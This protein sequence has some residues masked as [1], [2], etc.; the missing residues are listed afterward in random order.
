MSA[1][2]KPHKVR[3]RQLE[4][5]RE[6]DPEG[7]I[8]VH[9]RTVDTLGKMLRSGTISQEMHEA[10]KD[11][12]AAFIVANLDPLRALPILRVPGTGRDPDLNDRQLHARRRVHKALQALGGISSP[13]GSCVWH[14]VGL[15][16][17]VREWAIRQGWGGRPVR[18]E[19]AQGIL[20]A[21]LGVLAAHFGY[22]EAKRAS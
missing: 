1:R 18:Q 4:E 9:H 7:R 12:E 17:S 10:A 5:I 22:G 15:Q 3:G 13:A 14:V 11:F 6:K 8:V 2:I 20:V 21:A 16:R 19:Q